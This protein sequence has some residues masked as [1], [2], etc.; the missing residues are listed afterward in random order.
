MRYLIDGYNLLF[1]FFD[2]SDELKINRQ[3]FIRDFYEKTQYLNLNI[4][5][6]FDSHYRQD[7]GSKNHLGNMEII[8]TSI[9]QSA[10]E[11]IL[12]FLEKI[13]NAAEYTVVTS[14]KTLSRLSKAYLVNTIGAAEFL[15]WLNKRYKSKTSKQKHAAIKPKERLP[16]HHATQK[17]AV[18]EELLPE[19]GSQAYYQE[20]FEKRYQEI[21]FKKQAT[22]R[23]KA[24]ANDK[25]PP[26]YQSENPLV[27][28]FERWLL[29]FSSNE[30]LDQ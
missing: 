5:L 7:E 18:Q 6:V 15:S 24:K 22:T 20:I 21:P 3:L 30:K 14:D 1:R 10:D 16:K 29:S 26:R 28:D 13:K 23:K 8:F 19:K 25:K 4:I 17:P 12:Q 27:S 9:G 11:F 2:S